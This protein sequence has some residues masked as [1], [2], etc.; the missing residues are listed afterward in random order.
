METLDAKGWK[1]HSHQPPLAGSAGKRHEVIPG[2][3]IPSWP[4]LPSL[5]GWMQQAGAQHC[6]PSCVRSPDDARALAPD[7]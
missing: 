7:S 2:S 5:Q 1:P 4:L 3:P 6:L